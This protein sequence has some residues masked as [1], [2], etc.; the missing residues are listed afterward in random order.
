MDVQLDGKPRRRTGSD[1][2]FSDPD[3]VAEEKQDCEQFVRER[4][5][6]VGVDGSDLDALVPKVMDSFEMTYTVGSD[7]PGVT[8]YLAMARGWAIRHDEFD[9]M[10]AL[11]KATKSMSGVPGGLAATLM[12][13]ATAGVLT[14]AAV[15]VLEQAYDLVR[16]YRHQGAYFDPVRMQV[17][18]FLKSRAGEA[19]ALDVAAHLT[20]LDGRDVSE[21]EA[22]GLLQSLLGVKTRDGKVVD[23]VAKND[24]GSWRSLA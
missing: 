3:F 13:G 19:R 7:V 16:A 2:M 17:L 18:V 5:A 1:S 8:S 12:A 21:T 24:D 11:V 14:I 9:L 23:F 10:R 6:E 20:F 4:L 22:D 15:N